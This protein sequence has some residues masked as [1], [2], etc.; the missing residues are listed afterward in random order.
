MWNVQIIYSLYS[1]PVKQ[2]QLPYLKYILNLCVIL[3]MCS[4][5]TLLSSVYPL[6]AMHSLLVTYCSKQVSTL[7]I[8]ITD[9]LYDNKCLV[10]GNYI[11]SCFMTGTYHMYPDLVSSP[12]FLFIFYL[13]LI[14]FKGWGH[15]VA[16]IFTH[17]YLFTR[18]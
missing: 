1:A 14:F 16:F 4:L 17:S 3:Y 11:S 5:V 15:L 10:L 7:V 12:P 8:E 2:D 13:F 18:L 6:S 9:H